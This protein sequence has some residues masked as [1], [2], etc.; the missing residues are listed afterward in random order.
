M[1]QTAKITARLRT[2]PYFLEDSSLQM[3]NVIGAPRIWEIQ[4]ISI[5]L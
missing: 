5:R 3:T 2:L 4:V 1:E